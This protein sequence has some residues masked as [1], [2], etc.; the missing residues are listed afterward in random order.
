VHEA[1]GCGLGPP[2]DVAVAGRLSADGTAPFGSPAGVAPA[3][4]GRAS[5][6]VMMIEVSWDI[7]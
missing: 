1:A 2:G 5:A 4:T 3:T 6:T 7:S